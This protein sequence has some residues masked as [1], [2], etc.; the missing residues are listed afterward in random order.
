MPYLIPLKY[1]IIKDIV[2]P[3]D[4]KNIEDPEKTK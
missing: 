4:L 2:L 3:K 1:I